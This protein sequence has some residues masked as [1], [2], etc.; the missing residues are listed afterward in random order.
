MNVEIGTDTP[1]FLCWEYLFQNFGILSLQCVIRPLGKVKETFF[2]IERT[3]LLIIKFRK[4]TTH[5]FSKVLY[6]HNFTC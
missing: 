5:L 4:Q 6:G 2:H 3:G 1:I